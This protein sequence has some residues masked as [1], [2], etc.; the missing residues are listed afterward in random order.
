MFIFLDRHVPHNYLEVYKHEQ[1]IL[2][3][4]IVTFMLQFANVLDIILASI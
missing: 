2:K 4:K 3:T 1:Y